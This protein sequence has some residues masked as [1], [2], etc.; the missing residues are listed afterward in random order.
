MPLDPPDYD[1]PEGQVRLLIADVSTDDTKRLLGD[2]AVTGFLT[3]NAGNI[4]RAAADA[5]DAIADS[6]ALVSKV[7][8]TQDLQTDGA[9]VADSLRKHAD[10]LRAQADTADDAEDD[11]FFDIV[12]TIQPRCRPELTERPV[13][14]GL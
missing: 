3:M 6:E 13:V 8:R 1:T 5:L 2:D 10:R 9:K 7:I 4:K 12:D 14:W 11:G